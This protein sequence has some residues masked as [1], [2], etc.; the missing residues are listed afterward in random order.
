M[1]VEHSG[2]L[3]APVDLADSPAAETVRQYA[4]EAAS[5]GRQAPPC[6]HR[7]RHR[8]FDKL[9]PRQ[10][11]ESETRGVGP[12]V[13][14]VRDRSDARRV[15]VALLCELH[16]CPRSALVDREAGRSVTGRADASGILDGAPRLGEILAE[17]RTV[18]GVDAPMV[19][20]VACDLVSSVRDFAQ[21]RSVPL[22]YPAQREERGLGL[23][24]VEQ[25]ENLADVA[26]DAVRQT[27]PIAALDHVLECADVKPVL[28]VYGEYVD[29]CSQ[30]HRCHAAIGRKGDSIH[31]A[32]LP[33]R[34]KRPWTD[35][36]RF[37]SSRSASS[38]SAGS[39]AP[40][41]TLW[42]QA[43]PS[44]A[45]A[46]R[47]RDAP[48]RPC[49]RRS[50]SRAR[51]PLVAAPQSARRVPP[52]ACRIL[53][54]RYRAVRPPVEP[55]A[56]PASPSWLPVQPRGTPSPHASRR[57]RTSTSR[58]RSAS[59]ARPRRA[60]AAGWRSGSPA[61][62]CPRSLRR[63]QQKPV[64][65]IAGCPSNRPVRAGGRCTAR[66]RCAPSAPGGAPQ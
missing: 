7:G 25:V 62:E 33:L 28:D 10:R 46:P 53:R 20:A 26:I 34:L 5:T 39:S 57:G 8:N 30:F 51:P 40:A 59:A 27:A 31:A 36:S 63:V 52:R 60:A 11:P 41:R 29:D 1:E 56:Q 48:P 9:R 49:A 61:A 22:R 44:V 50:G 16:E 6:E 55:S 17:A 37:R 3:V 65:Q 2:S 18:H 35:P 15:S 66:S 24:L 43:E 64:G 14:V 13:M 19:P 42:L 58:R 32:M 38:G 23:G 12:A 54:E 47:A 21:Q 45:V 4:E